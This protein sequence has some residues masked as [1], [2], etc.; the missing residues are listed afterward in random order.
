MSVVTM[1]LNGLLS[2]HKD[3]QCSVSFEEA[4]IELEKLLLIIKAEVPGKSIAFIAV[5]GAKVTGNIMIKN[6]DC[7]DIFPAVTG[8]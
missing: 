6:G 3:N 2:H 7:V 4:A 5:N 1:R 8:G